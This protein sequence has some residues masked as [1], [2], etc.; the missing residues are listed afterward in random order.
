MSNDY[1]VT[2]KLQVKLQTFKSCNL[3]ILLHTL[4]L[5][6]QFNYKLTFEL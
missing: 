6:V 5:S 3:K 4:Y 2:K 1:E